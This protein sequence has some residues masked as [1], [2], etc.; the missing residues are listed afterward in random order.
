[1]N[2]W[3]K[4]N[5]IHIAIILFFVAL[6]F[7]YFMPAFQG[8]LLVQH[9]VSQ[10]SAMQREIMSF[11]EKDGK[12]PLWTNAMFGGMPSYQIWATYPKNITTYILS[13]FRAVF[14]N[15]VDMVMLYLL[16]SYF[17]FN[18]LL[19]RIKSLNKF[20]IIALSVIGAIAFAFSSYNFIILEAGHGNK[21]LAIGFFAPILAGVLLAFRGN[22]WMGMGITALSLSLAIRANHI[23]M[24]YYLALAL[25]LLVI[26][27][28]VVAYKNKTLP[29]V[30]KAL[31]FLSIAVVISV[32][33]NASMLWTTYEYGQLSI[34]GKSNLKS[35]SSAPASSGLDKEYAYQWSQ[36]VGE[37]ITFLI[38]NAYGGSSSA[39]L[40]KDSHVAKTLIAKGVDANQAVG[41]AQQLPTYWGPKPFTSG[42]WYFGAIILFLFVF[43]LFVV[44]SKLKWWLIAATVLSILLSFGKNFDLIS[45]LFFDY[46]PLYNKFRA[47]ESILVIVSL[48]LPI[49]AIMAIVETL[50]A[51][52]DQKWLLSKLKLSGYIVGGILILLWIAPTALFSFRADNH[53]D[54]INQLNQITGDSGFANSIAQSLIQDRVDMFKAD[55]LRSLGFVIFGFAMLWL[56][57]SKKLNTNV[58]IIALGVF[59]L[60]DLWT[61]DKRYLNDGKFV[62][63]SVMSQQWQAREVDDFILRDK[64]PDFRV[65]DLTIPTFSSAN[66]TYFH[67]TVGGYHA[68]KLKRFQEVIEKQFSG[69]LNQDVL[70]MLNTKYFITSGQDGQNVSMKI[71]QTACGHAWFV[72][73]VQFVK[74]NDEEMIAIS[75]F[76]PKKEAII[77]DEF[78]KDLDL[79]HIGTSAGGKIELVNY[80]PDNLKYEYSIGKKAVAVFSE[81][82]YPKGW[83][84]Y[85]DG[86][87]QPYIRANYLLRAAELPAGNHTVEW[88]FEPKSYY[89]GENISLIGSVLLSLVLA[90]AIFRQKSQE[91]KA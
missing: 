45:N 63:K 46:F 84:M 23:Q 9:D 90:F 70:D 67:N 30:L 89:F 7:V 56:L 24:T 36:G 80:H 31:G 73:N 47:V 21:A 60:A 83:K 86:E 28:L 3:F 40:T 34:R 77:N 59:I 20:A 25:L 17:F 51:K 10:A 74:D 1:M 19:L 87:E 62:T 13:G 22:S 48:C 14:P 49:L 64:D 52:N 11:K 6:C 37:C 5:G 79:N 29:S 78:K 76:D 32:T 65:L 69:S 81:I 33:V 39:G 82:W 55:T 91:Q 75:S 27:E 50:K 41:F 18:V 43:G 85:V 8:K 16:G 57:I 58:V 35:E 72:D 61:V 38:P 26:I 4:R 2:N 44:K 88:K 12:A 68:A 15:P 42:P 66:A 53:Q 71:N 54:F